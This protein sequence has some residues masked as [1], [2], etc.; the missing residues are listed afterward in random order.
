MKR[1]F[2]RQADAYLVEAE[3]SNGWK[4]TKITKLIY[5]SKW[6]DVDGIN[7]EMCSHMEYCA[8]IDVWDY[9]NIPEGTGVA[10]QACSDIADRVAKDLKKQLASLYNVS[11]WNISYCRIK[12]SCPCIKVYPLMA[13]KKLPNG[14]ILVYFEGTWYTREEVEKVILEYVEPYIKKHLSE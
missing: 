10:K 12:I 7:P 6:E 5:M 14:V 1:P 4:D 11:I 13:G 3:F 2:N 9:M 8:S